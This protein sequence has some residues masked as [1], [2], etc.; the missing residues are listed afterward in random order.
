MTNNDKKLNLFIR[1]KEKLIFGGPVSTVTSENERGV[2]DI[3][4]GHTNFLT[5]IK[6]YVI[7]DKSLPTEQKYPVQKGMLYVLG[8][9]VNIYV[10]L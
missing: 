7:T 5:L 9:M 6:D 4:Y 2:F 10:G 8:D 1:S 3:L